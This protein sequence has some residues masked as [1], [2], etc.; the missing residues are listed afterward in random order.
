LAPA[1]AVVLAL[2]LRRRFGVLLAYVALV[3]LVL[4][5]SRGGLATGLLVIAVW[6]VFGD[7]RVES[8]VCLL[9]A[10]VPA[11][12][13]VGI[14]FALPGVTSDAQSARVRWRGGLGFGVVLVARGAATLAVERVPRLRDRRLLRGVAVALGAAAVLAVVVVAIHGTGSGTPGNT[15]SRFVS[16]NSN[17]RFT[18]W[19]QAWH[20]FRD[21]PLA[22]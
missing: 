3:A 10:A 19:E 6:L 9:A 4:T 17:L 18:W 7:D 5:Y 16:T 1:F 11:A 22:G 14:A 12:I 2:G 21:H 20:G 15:Q 8:A 13:V